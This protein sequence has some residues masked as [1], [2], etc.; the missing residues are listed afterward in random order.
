MI[1]ILDDRHT[2]LLDAPPAD[3][4]RPSMAGILLDGGGQAS[5]LSG[6]LLNASWCLELA[7]YT[8]DQHLIH[9]GADHPANQHP[10]GQFIRIK[11]GPSPLPAYGIIDPRHSG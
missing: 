5:T 6:P 2:E 8:P 4:R 7:A 1:G 9:I 10:A 11:K 3:C